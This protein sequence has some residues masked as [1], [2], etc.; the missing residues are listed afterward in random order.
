V[1]DPLR[2]IADEIEAASAGASIESED[3]IEMSDKEVPD[4]E[5]PDKEARGIATD[6]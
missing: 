5:I 1:D 2:A 4:K 6:A 3:K